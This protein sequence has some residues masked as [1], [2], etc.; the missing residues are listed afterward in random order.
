[1]AYVK[2]IHQNVNIYMYKNIDISVNY[3]LAGI[4]LRGNRTRTCNDVFERIQWAMV[5]LHVSFCPAIFLHY[6]DQL[7]S[8]SGYG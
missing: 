6:S 4:I 7:E 2:I 8:K 5:P 3:I 1:M